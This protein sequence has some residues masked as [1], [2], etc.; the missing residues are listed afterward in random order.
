MHGCEG[1][2][3]EGDDVPVVGSGGNMSIAVSKPRKAWS[4]TETKAENASSRMGTTVKL[5][6]F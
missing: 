6:F 3:F 4:S 5:G 2:E 1:D